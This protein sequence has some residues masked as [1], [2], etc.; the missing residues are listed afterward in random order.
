MQDAELQDLL[1]FAAVAR[2]RSFRGAAGQQ[3]VSASGLSA[4][5]RRLEDR[6]G[7]RLLN[8]TTRSVTPTDAGARLLDRLGPALSAVS[9][10]VD[11][12][13]SY[14]DTPTGTLRLNVP[15][16]VADLIL[17]D[18]LARF[19][20]AHPAIR[21]EVM[22]EDSFVDV[23]GQGFD[24]GVRYDER[25]E[26][27]MIAVPI[28]RRLD[29]YACVAAPS[30]LER[31]GRPQHPHDLLQHQC[32]RHRFSHGVSLPWE[33]ERSG[34]L[35]KIT[36]K[37]PLV[38]NRL[39]LQR[40]AVVAGFG[41][42]ASFVGFYADLI[43]SGAVEEILIDWAE[44]FSGPFLFYAERRHMPAPLRAFVDFIREDQRRLQSTA[45]S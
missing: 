22:A 11:S 37:G 27:D 5:V 1:A 35:V 8:R 42:A 39:A 6:L 43:E 24:A 41:I 26:K 17:P 14:R 9:D 12:V 33:F 16:V 45:L 20:A 23:L 4:A 36:P 40:A 13:N 28:G 32:I 19:M 21:V 25:L 15:G 30:Y 3:G 38:T 2:S 31:H 34:E 18:I 29:R 44:P 7:V 10:A